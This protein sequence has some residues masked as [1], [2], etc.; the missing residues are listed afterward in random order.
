MTSQ[1]Y[2][3]VWPKFESCFPLKKFDHHHVTR[4]S[5]PCL[6][7]KYLLKKRKQAITRNDEESITRL[8]NQINR[9]IHSNQVNAVKSEKHGSKKWWNNNITGRIGNSLPITVAL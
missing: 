4:R 1:F 9:I 2:E 3:T 5:C 6:H 7:V 8:Q